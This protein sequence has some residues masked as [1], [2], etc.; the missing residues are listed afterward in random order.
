MSKFFIEVVQD[1]DGTYYANMVVSGSPV[2]GLKEHVDYNTLRE[3][4]KVKT[5]IEIL[6]KKDMFFQQCGRKKYAYIDATQYRGEGKD[7][8]VTLDEMRSGWKP[9]F[10]E[11]KSG[12]SPKP[13]LAEQIKAAE[14]KY[15]SAPEKNQQTHSYER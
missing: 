13:S 15:Y 12:V 9:D 7:C 10:N 3:D 6:K 8:R 14:T 11:G 5:G 4:I 2:R 1:F